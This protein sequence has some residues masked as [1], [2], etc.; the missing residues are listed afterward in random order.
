MIKLRKLNDNSLI[1]V[2][3][4]EG[5]SNNISIQVKKEHINT[6]YFG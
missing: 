6:A 2:L 3:Y 1:I 5:K 4:T